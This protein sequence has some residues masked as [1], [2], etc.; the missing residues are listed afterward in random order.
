M[1][2]LMKGIKENWLKWGSV[3]YVFAMLLMFYMGIATEVNDLP[4]VNFRGS[5]YLLLALPFLAVFVGYTIWCAVN[6]R[7]G[8]KKEATQE[9]TGETEA[10]QKKVKD[11]IVPIIGIFL[12][13]VSRVVA[14]LTFSSNSAPQDGKYVIWADEYHVS[15][16]PVVV[17]KYYLAG[18]KVQAKGSEL[19][20]YTGHSVVELDFNRDGT[21]YILIEGKKLGCV[22]GKNGV[23]YRD[24]CTC[25]EWKL[26]EVEEGVYY[27]KNTANNT[28]L[29]WFD[30]QENWTTHPN[31]VDDNRS[32]YLLRLTPAE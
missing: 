25:T 22:P 32:Q 19:T 12:A 20:D 4:G 3:P 9:V 14:V 6:S 13:V 16:T 29:K 24:D 27:I 28:Y 7:G 26:E 15:L 2:E 10:P 8:K 23:G 31:I 30:M 11:P 21:F 5:S 1:E 17:N 18:D